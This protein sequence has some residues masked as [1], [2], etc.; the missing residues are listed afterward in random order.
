MLRHSVFSPV[1]Q[2]AFLRLTLL[3]FPLLDEIVAGFML[4]GGLPLLRD[5]YHLSYEQVGFL[6]S[7]GALSA[8]I[9]EPILNL[10]S[11]QSSSK[12]WWI[13]GGLLGL[14][15]GFALAASAPNFIVLLAA[16]ALSYPAGGA[17]I[18]LSEAALIESAPDVGAR[19]MTR[20]TVMAT[21]GDLLSP[22]IVA[23]FVALGLGW[24]HLCWLAVIAWIVAGL[25]VW[26]QK[27]PRPVAL[28]DD[29]EN[30]S[31]LSML[32]GFR[33]ALRDPILLRWAIIL[34]VP[35]MLDE[36]LTGFAALYL[37]DVL[38]ADQI[39]ISSIIVVQMTGALLGLLIVDRLLGRIAP[40][41]LLI[42]LTVLSLIGVIVLLSIHSIVWAACALF[43]VDLGAAGLYPLAQAEAYACYPGRA[44]TVR[45]VIG[46]A[47]PFEIALPGLVGL[48]ASHFG[49]LAGVGLLGCAPLLILLLVPWRTHK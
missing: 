49:P 2:T 32:A 40:H 30:S 29:S 1:R 20:W 23:V 48:V 21:F 8:L 22:L 4:E 33:K 26:P 12:R 25:L 28:L 36:V 19:S 41:R 31:D 10:L 6:F 13:L 35:T 5:Q 34:L 44:G 11:D 3:S 43:V 45:A 17:A 7:V 14:A 38:H 37:H 9:L 42:C 24:S 27:F 18:G 47:T 16:L 39:V 46:L 15:C